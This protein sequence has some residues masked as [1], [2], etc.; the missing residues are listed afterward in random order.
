MG[1]SVRIFSLCLILKSLVGFGQTDYWVRITNDKDREAYGYADQDG[2]VK[3][4]FGKYMMCFTDTFSTCAIVMDRRGFIGIDREENLLFNVYPF[5]NGPDYP[6]E[7][8]FRIIDN[9]LIGFA[10]L[11]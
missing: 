7:G 9:G 5:D 3:I 6:S 10:D 2:K 4:P 1:I 11:T 8:L